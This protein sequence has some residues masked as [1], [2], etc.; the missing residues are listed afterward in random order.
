MEERRNKRFMEVGIEKVVTDQLKMKEATVP[1]QKPM[2]AKRGKIFVRSYAMHV[3]RVYS[4]EFG[5]ST[6]PGVGNEGKLSF[7]FCSAIALASARMVS[8][9]SPAGKALHD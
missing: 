5:R 2:N 1:I 8:A 4:E 9:S 3:H 6:E 7:T